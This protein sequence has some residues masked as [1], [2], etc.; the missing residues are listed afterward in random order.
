MQLMKVIHI[1][2]LGDLDKLIWPLNKIGLFSVKTCYHV[3]FDDSMGGYAL[4]AS[5]SSSHSLHFYKFLWK[6]DVAPKLCIFCWKVL[7]S[8]VLNMLY[9]VLA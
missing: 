3:L 1:S 8:W 2:R 7:H 4:K 5:F 9:F 6:I